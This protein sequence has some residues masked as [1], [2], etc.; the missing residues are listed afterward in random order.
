MQVGDKVKA[1]VVGIMSYGYALTFYQDDVRYR[2]VLKHK[3]CSFDVNGTSVKKGTVLDCIIHKIRTNEIELDNRDHQKTQDNFDKIAVGEVYSGTV[4]NVLDFGVFVDI[5]EGIT[6]MI[7]KNDLS[8]RHV[9]S[10][11]KYQHGDTISALVLEKSL[12][13]GKVRIVLSS[14]ALQKDPW[15][16]SVLQCEGKSFSGV[17]NKIQG[18]GAFIGIEE[19]NGIDGLLHVS[20]YPENFVPKVG[21][22]IQVMV[23]SVNQE[24][25]RMSLV[26]PDDS[27]EE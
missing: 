12:T 18:Y 15:D 6:G 27:T 4:R 14:K 17:V 24:Q 21:M 10:P 22:E 5:A 9:T 19:L 23:Q 2:A 16:E 8:H 1:K 11:Y 7:H 3:L 25:Q 20:N 13:N 26:L